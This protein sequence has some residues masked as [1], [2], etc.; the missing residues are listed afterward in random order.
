VASL[1]A[2]RELHA[3]MRDAR[4]SYAKCGELELRIELPAPQ[5]TFVP[6]DQPDP[7]ED[8]RRS[9]GTLLHSAGV[10]AFLRA[11]KKAV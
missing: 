11:L 5:S 8:E 4:V 9:L 1:D 6:V 2:L 7:D 10:E 3:W